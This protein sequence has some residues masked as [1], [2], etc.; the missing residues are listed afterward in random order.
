MTLEIEDLEM[1]DF[2]SVCPP[3]R[4]LKAEDLDAL[5]RAT[6]VSYAR[7]NS[8]IIA[9]DSVNH[10][11]FLVRSGA[12]EI[13]TP[14]GKIHSHVC[15]G[16]WFG[17]RSSMTGGTVMMA[18]EAL[19][20]TLLYQI[21]SEIMFPFLEKFPRIGTFFSGKKAVRLRSAISET[22]EGTGGFAS[23]SFLAVGELMNR[24]ISV[25][26]NTS[27]QEA[28]KV[29]TRENTSSL[30]IRQDEAL[31]GVVTDHNLRE[32]VV[33]VAKNLQ[34]PISD[35]MSS[36]VISIAKDSK[37]YDAQ[38]AMV[39][40][41]IQ[42]L[43]VIE[44]NKLVGV[45]TARDMIKA[46]GQVPVF[47]V[48]DIYRASKLSELYSY[49][50]KVPEILHALVKQHLPS[51]EIGKVISSIGEAINIRLLQMA[52]I[53]LGK[54]PVP[55][56]WG[57]AGSMARC[58]Q[59]AH[60]DQD[61][62]LILSDDFIEAEHGD[63]FRALAKYVSDGLHAC[64]YIYCPGNVMA[65]NP[66]WFMT[67]SQWLESFRTWV[68]EPKPKA[69]MYCSIFFDMR[70]IYG[71][72][73]LFDPV[74]KYVRHYAP[75]N[76]IFLSYMM[77][78]SMQHRPPL[79]FFRNFVLEDH[80][81]HEDVLDLKKRG[82]IPIVD[83][84]RVCGLAGGA[85]VVSTKQRLQQSGSTC[86]SQEGLQDL[87]DAYEVINAIRL[88]YQALNIQQG[89]EPNNY[90]SPKDMT[91]MERRHLKDAFHIVSTY[92]EAL[93]RHYHVESL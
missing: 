13:L 21:P 41:N 66:E 87:G 88:H 80:G 24:A 54:P 68:E 31:L 84:A 67:A 14:E 48:A 85:T 27:I 63:Y 86:I 29:M 23:L 43:P 81:D 36:P 6:E 17:Y 91:S 79:G 47:L 30:I 93:A 35:I 16:E 60:S 92:Q 83:L 74:L 8:T 22:K 1:R 18:V 72:K 90:V 32:R 78:N 82:V 3:L 2:L 57:V 76:T 52:E 15:E 50:L 19:E 58:E 73:S 10:F 42:A 25:L 62:A 9:L 53:E 70:M 55:Y 71:E 75:K 39:E 89:E 38:L 20:D 45:I 7:R 69:L 5:T 59:V 56:A 12:V 51:E 61:N 11:F 33:A 44:K 37:L 26:P 40:N 34:S 77:A 49:A 4:E 28:A 65:T 46:Q 64:G